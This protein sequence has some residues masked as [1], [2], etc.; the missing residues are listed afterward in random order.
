MR[1]T[2][3]LLLFLLHSLVFCQNKG[4][5]FDHL[6]T[7]NGLSQ[8][9]VLCILQ[10]SKGFMWFGTRDGLNKYDGYKF[11]VYKNN[12]ANNNSVSNNNILCM[13]EYT[14][15]LLCLGTYGG[16]LNFF[17]T[18]TNSF[19]HFKHSDN[20][21]NSIASDYVNS[22]VKDVDNNLWI[23]T[24]GGGLDMYNVKQNKFIHYRHRNNDSSSIG[25]DF[26]RQVY[27][28]KSGQLWVS[29][30][31]SG[32]NLL[33]KS[34]GTFKRYTHNAKNK[35][36]ISYND[37][38][39]TYEDSKQRLW[40]GTNGGGLDLMNRATGEFTHYKH[41]AFD[42]NSISN[43]ILYI[44][45]EDD[46]GKIWIG[47]ENGGVSIF[48]PFTQT[49]LTFESDEIDQKSLGNNSIY[50]I[51]KDVKGNIW[52]G[53]FSEGISIVNKDNSRFQ[54]YRHTSES[55]SLSSN[56][57][58]NIYEDSDN[59]LWVT[60]DGGGLNK[61]DA[62]TGK[63]THFKHKEGNTSSIC[64]DYVL[65][66]AEDSDHNLWIGTWADGISVY[67]KRTGG[68]THFKN[69]PSDNKSLSN[70]N[71][72][73]I[74][75]DY[76]KNIWIGT[77]GGGL[78]LYDKATG[79]FIRYM[80][81]PENPQS[82]N[83]D[84]IHTV[85][86]DSRH[87][88]WIG[89]DG[90]GL[91]LFDRKSK[92]FRHF[93]NDGTNKSISDN[94]VG[95]IYEDYNGNLWIGTAKGLSLMNEASGTFTSYTTKDGLPNDVIFGILQDKKGYL[96][97]STNKGI[98]KFNAAKKIFK[99]YSVADGLQSD[100]FK[101][102]AFCKT[103]TGLMYFGGNNGFNIF[104]PEQVKDIPFD[105]PLV[106]TSLEIFNQPVH[107]TDSLHDTPLSKDISDT[108]SITLSYKQSIISFEFASLNYVLPVRKQYRYMLEGFDKTWN[109]AGINNTITYTNL[110]AGTY[111]LK[112]Q[113]LNNEGNWS[114]KIS[115]LQLIIKPPFWKTW[116][117]IL[118]VAVALVS[119]VITLYR[120]RINAIKKQKKL[121]E[122]Q[123]HERTLQ[124]AYSND[125]EHKARVEAETARLEAEQANKAKSVF[126]ATMS[127]EIRTPLNG[128]IGMSALLSETDL[129]I[130]QQD[131][132]DTI[133]SCG[134]SL[135]TVINDILDFSKIES[136]SMELEQ[137]NVDLRKNIEEVLDVFANKAAKTGI[138]LVYE[139][140]YNV[141]PQILGDSIRLKQ[142]LMNLV[143]NAIKFTSKGEIYVGVHLLKDL[144]NN[145]VQLGFEVRDTGIGIPHDK[146]HR[147]F[148]AFSQ[149]D[150]S[151]TRE[152]GGTGLGLIICEKLIQLMHGSIN[153]ESEQGKG[154]RFYFDIVTTKSFQS[155]KVYAYSNL[156][157]IEGKHVLVVDD[158]TT[159]QKIL[160]EQLEHWKLI[161]R[162]ASSG[163]EALLLL[164][165]YTDFDLVISDMHMP[166]MDGL[167]L[168]KIIKQKHPLLPVM[169][170]SSV[171]EENRKEYR[172]MFSA[173]LNKPVK[174]HILQKHVVQVLKGQLKAAPQE[175]A[176]ANG[177]EAQQF[178]DLHPLNILVAEDNQVN[179]KLILILLRKLGYTPEITDNGRSVIELLSKKKYDM[180]L[181][182]IHMPRLDGLEATKLIR[183]EGEYQPI[184][185]ALT[186]D[187][188]EETRQL[189][190]STGM[191]DYMSKPIQAE[192]LNK[193]LE[194]WSNVIKAQ[195]H[196]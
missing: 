5:Q 124:L 25:D 174:Q 151:T 63:F 110:D 186:A 100:E 18:Q 167:Q 91:N 119:I 192:K 93:M 179:Q 145:Q 78:N 15:G 67:N 127:H 19:K 153:V 108:K 86:E 58:L 56:K 90:G 6:G 173:I 7:A 3:S 54:Y 162:I 142:I 166:G 16:G 44:A 149:V 161:A 193:Q 170:L 126:L 8:S 136:G 48:N 184:I 49:F 118:L 4:I 175:K 138:D 37:I 81:D 195:I 31:N 27:I 28:D 188:T 158:N 103:H 13:L 50:A 135:M 32:L 155:Q 120:F 182:D 129:N 73:T 30:I 29:T 99:N 52:L 71:A 41:N 139:I 147:L 187:A 169:L 24:E 185:I 96:W 160:R 89:T 47:T 22:I 40:V 140:D 107:I 14:P 113:G 72:W 180:V 122:Q 133:R 95:T 26:I 66:V 79:T 17:N 164:E 10:D 116:W 85:F 111:T 12:E 43:N 92:T 178:A 132:A 112:I 97:I 83:S 38:R 76:E 88:L 2:L 60:T 196:A 33:D 177:N 101:E 82:L 165:Q 134:E 105:P 23:G 80:Y 159:N 125:L 157:D 65:H 45:M 75:E 9:N 163:K 20:N 168:T 156:S 68:F 191:N 104:N 148:K 74:Y 171:T 137:T 39:F 46:D 64:G 70:N 36:S 141:P 61:F 189:C 176:A 94:S 143:G 42:K 183:L 181:M 53:T 172:E 84:K 109:N 35:N 121:L 55:S 69:N 154:T 11:V 117:F 51:Y 144:P 115:T 77:Y 146:I 194:K 130:E 87:R 131:Y 190:L 1:Y 102:M 59:D 128:V 62:L 57:V 21:S 106:L 123:V 150:S 114:A 152:Y 98:S 34:N